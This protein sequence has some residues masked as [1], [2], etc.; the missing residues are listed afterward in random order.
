MLN[1]PKNDL[2]RFQVFQET[3][4]WCK[5]VDVRF[6]ATWEKVEAI[7]FV[8]ISI[9]WRQRISTWWRHDISFRWSH[10]FEEVS[11]RFGL[12]VQLD[13]EK[14][15]TLQQIEY[16]LNWKKIVT[17]K[18]V[19]YLRKANL[20]CRCSFIPKFVCFS[21]WRI[22]CYF[23]MQTKLFSEVTDIIINIGHLYHTSIHNFE[24]VVWNEDFLAV[25]KFLKDFF[26]PIFFQK[27]C[28]A[29]LRV[30]LWSTVCSFR[31]FV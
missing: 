2:F 22:S 26:A 17:S 25:Q 16:F 10:S 29:Y 6:S 19:A 4:H 13:E 20:K 15:K 31:K 9:R 3:L 11:E 21:F 18:I 5:G 12:V 23:Q 14:S 8:Q 1:R 30:S 28:F 7:G 27:I 24:F